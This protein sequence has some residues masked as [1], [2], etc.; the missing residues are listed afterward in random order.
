MWFAYNNI[1]MNETGKDGCS[2]CGK[3]QTH[4]FSNKF[5]KRISW[6]YCVQCNKTAFIF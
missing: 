4:G 5:S 6:I 2:D 1:A 3:M